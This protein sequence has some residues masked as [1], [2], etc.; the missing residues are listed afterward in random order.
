MGSHIGQKLKPIFHIFMVA[1]ITG[2]L[3][4]TEHRRV[5]YP[6]HIIG[7]A[8]CSLPDNGI[9]ID[10]FVFGDLLFRVFV[11]DPCCASA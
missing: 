11:N 1:F 6:P 3:S 4:S 9:F 2:N 7:D 10:L 8:E 5:G